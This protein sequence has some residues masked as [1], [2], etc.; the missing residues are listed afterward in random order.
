MRV[1]YLAL[2]QY[3]EPSPG[4]QGTD[5]NPMKDKRV[6]EALSLALNRDAIVDRVMG[7][8]AKPAGN[9]L[10]YPM[11]GSSKEHSQ[12]PKAD[13]EKAKALLKEAGYPN[14]FS[15]TLG[16]PS[17]RY[18]NDAKVAQAIASMW[19]RI[20]VK[21]S[22]DSMAPPVF[23]KNRDSYAFS[24]YLAGWSVTSGEM[25]NALTSLL[26]TRNPE[27]GLGTT[28][29]SRY[30]NPAMDELV[31]QASS[32]MDDAKRAELLQKASNLAMD[33]Y[34]MLPVHFELSVWA[35]KNDIRYTG[36]PD[37]TTLV[38]YATV[39]K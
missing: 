26:V 13:V 16:S 9:L 8:V 1:V 11:F 2:D 4:V 6:R 21:T 34:A 32:T 38:Q 12:A 29:R 7:G 25:S 23:F 15:I 10:P 19:T 14:G 28:N 39:K 17:G 31:K 35:M 5:K 27:A 22:V 36:R 24:A 20:G 33:D 30:S 3:A 37:Q 18:V